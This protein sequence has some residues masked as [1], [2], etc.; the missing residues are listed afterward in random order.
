MKIISLLFMVIATLSLVLTMVLGI[1][2]KVLPVGNIPAHS[3]LQFTVVCL[4]F[5]IALSLFKTK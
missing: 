2:D 4:L 1:V 5:S 3:F